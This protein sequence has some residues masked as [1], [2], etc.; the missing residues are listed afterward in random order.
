MS[1]DRME[2]DLQPRKAARI[3]V[4]SEVRQYLLERNNYHCQS[5]GKAAQD[6]EL[7]VD[8][9][10]SLATGGSNDISNLQI[11]CRSCNSRK[12]HSYDSRFDRYFDL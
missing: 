2:V 3:H 11:L 5:C 4:P 12:K 6:V 8:H 9:I 7:T 10:I 1:N